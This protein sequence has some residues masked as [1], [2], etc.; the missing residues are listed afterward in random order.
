MYNVIVVD[1]ED[2]ICKLIRRIVDWDALGFRIVANAGDGL[3]ALDLIKEH[4][5]DLVITDIRMPGLDGLGLIKAVREQNLDVEFIIISGYSDFE[6]AR[7]AITFEA[8]AYLLKPLDKDEF[9][10]ALKGIKDK[11][12]KKRLLRSKI[13]TSRTVLLENA[14]KELVE[15]T[16]AD[17]NT[18]GFNEQY[19]TKFTDG[20]YYAAIF[21][22]DSVSRENREKYDKA[23]YLKF[24][25]EVK[26]R[27]L[28]A[29][30]EIVFFSGEMSNEDIFIINANKRN[31][32]A[33]PGV[34]SDIVGSYENE[35]DVKKG[36]RLTV[37]LS[38]P[39]ERLSGIGAA[40]S[41]AKKAML[42]RVYLGCGRVIDANKENSRIGGAKNVIDI[43]R[44]K[45]LGMLLDVLDV[46]GASLEISGI[47]SD[48]HSKSEGNLII[49]H[50]VAYRIVDLLLSAMQRKNLQVKREL[51]MQQSVLNIDDCITVNEIK[52]YVL[53]LL[54]ELRNTYLDEKHE[55]GEKL[56]AEIK[57]FIT[58][59]YMSDINLDDVAKLVCLSTTYVSEVFKRKT[60]ENFS[61][62]LID[63]RIEIAKNLLKD[64]RYKVIDVSSRVGYKDSKYFSRLFK[65][66]VGVNPSD[67]R[68][69]YL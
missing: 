12:S 15:K 22:R 51:S 50:T 61:E 19:G 45:K 47:F 60:G 63:Y 36:Y 17:I 18:G 6:Y 34:M 28:N 26:E 31:G 42:A 35:P 38:R 29:F 67:Y 11:L 52:V 59:K 10:D 25:W 43:Q 57:R 54:K 32:Q 49:N 65:K 23:E 62:Y 1:D 58:E 53:G 48:A 44:E 33:V 64:I 41:E 5:P 46:A 40:Y 66:K 21:K 69:L 9:L 7:S 30:G 13:E 56:I 55:N 3:S 39:V 24:L 20:V 4:K 68:K 27:Y 37:C 2:W 16:T 14:L 8:Q